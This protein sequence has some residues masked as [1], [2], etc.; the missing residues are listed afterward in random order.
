[1]ALFDFLGLKKT[2]SDIRAKLD[3]IDAEIVLLE[4]RRAE[5]VRLPLPFGD[6]VEWVCEQV[7]SEASG[8]PDAI[9]RAFR[10]SHLASYL[11]PRGEGYNATAD[12][13][14]SYPSSGVSV[15]PPPSSLR[16]NSR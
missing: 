7:D 13:Q 9:C 6:F 16:D 14:A 4:R 5:L 11:E 2:L 12:F 10:N 8:W 15:R 3:S 1:M